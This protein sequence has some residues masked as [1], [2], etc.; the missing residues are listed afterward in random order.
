MK[1]KSIKSPQKGK[2][3]PTISP[4]QNWR[5]RKTFSKSPRLAFSSSPI[6]KTSR[7][8]PTNRET[9]SLTPKKRKISK[10]LLLAFSSTPIRKTSRKSTPK[11]RKT[12]PKSPR[13]AFSSPHIRK[14][15][16]KSPTN[17]ETFSLTPKK[18]KTTPKSPRLALSPPPIRRKSLK[19]K[20]K[21]ISKYCGNNK[22][23]SQLREN[24]GDKVLGTNYECMRVG[25]GAGYHNPI[26]DIDEFLN[27]EPI[28][29]KP[30][31]WCGNGEQKEG[32][33]RGYPSDCLKKGF[34]AGQ[35][36]QAEENNLI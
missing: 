32:Y 27:Y 13:L 12:S 3:L 17:R 22:N 28:Y 1:K 10:S 11:K 20:S 8:S 23:S 9:F 26:A 16:R 29:I 15:S 21:R 6:R 30:K 14:T 4:I 34:G 7:K 2:K 25:F 19:I 35:R 31:M 36:K 33:V 18:R 5:F 24:G